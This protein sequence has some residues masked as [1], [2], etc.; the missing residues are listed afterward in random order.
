MDINSTK[1]SENLLFSELFSLD[2]V[3]RKRVEV[4]FTA[5]DLSSHGGLLLLGELD[6]RL[7]LIDRLAGCLR[8]RGRS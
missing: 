8:F 6:Y 7:D 1:Q 4:S 3:E 5:P 2:L